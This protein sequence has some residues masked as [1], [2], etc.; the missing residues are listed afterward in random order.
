MI[1][2]SMKPYLRDLCTRIVEAVEEGMSEPYV[3]WLSNVNFAPVERCVRGSYKGRTLALSKGGGSPKNDEANSKRSTPSRR[4]SRWSR[5]S[6]GKLRLAPGRPCN[7]SNSAA[8]DHLF[9]RCDHRCG[10]RSD[11]NAREASET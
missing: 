5:A 2:W 7:R 6:L 3:A 9:N 1:I 10:L 4:P 8:L 11:S